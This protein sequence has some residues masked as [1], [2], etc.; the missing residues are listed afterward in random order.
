[1]AYGA[2]ALLGG[3]ALAMAALSLPSVP[4]F[5]VGTA[6]AGTGFGA[7]FQGAMRSVLPH[8]AARDRAGVLSVILVVSYLAMGVPAV[9]AGFLVAEQGSVLTTAREFGA[10]VMALAAAALAGALLRRAQL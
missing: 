3:V 6:V 7:G 1:M 8:A 10:V 5:F 9:L 2:W 4:L